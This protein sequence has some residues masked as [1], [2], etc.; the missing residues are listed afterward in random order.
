MGE[1]SSQSEQKN[2]T[3]T[4][5]P[6]PEEISS[7]GEL[8]YVDTRASTAQLISLQAAADGRSNRSTTAQLQAKALS[9]AGNSRIAQ[10]QALSDSRTATTKTNPIQRAENKTGLPDQLKLGMESISGLSL[11]DV[12]VHRNSDKP[13]Q[14]QAHAYA[15]GTDIHLGPGQEKHLPHELGHVVQQKQGRVKPTMQ[16]KGKVNVNDDAGLEKEADVLGAKAINYKGSGVIALKKTTIPNGS[17]QKV[18]Q[19]KWNLVD[20]VIKAFSKVPADEKAL[21]AEFIANNSGKAPRSAEESAEITARQKAEGERMTNAGEIPGI[22]GYEPEGKDLLTGYVLSQK[23]LTEIEEFY[24]KINEQ[25]DEVSTLKKMLD[26]VLSSDAVAIATERPVAIFNNLGGLGESTSATG[27]AGIVNEA[28]G[29]KGLNVEDG[30][31]ADGGLKP[32]DSAAEDS[33]AGEVTPL[34]LPEEAKGSFANVMGGDV[35]TSGFDE[36][37]GGLGLAFEAV[38]HLRAEY[39]ASNLARKK[40]EINAQ[41]AKIESKKEM[42]AADAEKLK[43]LQSQIQE[44]TFEVEESQIQIYEQRIQL[45]ANGAR[46]AAWL[47]MPPVAAAM[48]AIENIVTIL[49]ARKMIALFDKLEGNLKTVAI[50][51][52]KRQVQKNGLMGAANVANATSPLTGGVGTVAAATL[53]TASAV[54][55]TASFVYKYATSTLGETRNQFATDLIHN[56]ESGNPKEKNEAIEA[57]KIL[58]IEDKVCKPDRVTLRKNAKQVIADSLLTGKNFDLFA[59]GITDALTFDELPTL[60]GRKA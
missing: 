3:A 55:Q 26:I 40:A 11:N 20:A 54:Q 59:K 34:G 24:I 23:D 41:I 48:T 28:L 13:A 60:Q 36:K 50:A 21:K 7:T 39:S 29:N 52:L 56:F 27:G 49:T 33:A 37:T 53:G 57:L 4:P 32:A 47:T 14:L 12:K 22:D 25:K 35:T 44:L 30:I 5:A 6:V 51:K 2:K 45:L 58:N 31:Q 15:Q 17:V 10:L 16:L 18:A 42:E 38:S 46:L 43:E 8:E 1:F 9:H 19:L